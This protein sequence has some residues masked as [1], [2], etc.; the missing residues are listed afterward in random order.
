MS[1]PLTDLAHVTR[2]L[3]ARACL[4]IEEAA[5]AAGMSTVTWLQLEAAELDPD[6]HQLEAIAKALAAD[7]PELFERPSRPV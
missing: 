7:L 4:T 5:A 2:R 3:R 1:D 6:L